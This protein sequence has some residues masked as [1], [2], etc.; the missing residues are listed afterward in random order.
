MRRRRKER[1]VRNSM[2][3]TDDEWARI[4]AAAAEAGEG[5]GRHI[6]RRALTDDPSPNALP[7]ASQA[8]AP[9]EQ[10]AMHDAILRLSGSASETA[11]PGQSWLTV[12]P[13][14]IRFLFEDRIIAMAREG[15]SEDLHAQFRS[16]FGAEKGQAMAAAF[17][18]RLNVSDSG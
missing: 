15:R 5:I 2:S 16:V 9:E 4:Q 11:V 12:L 7:R 13:G 18:R 8:L 17:L 1:V 14:C 3:C 10:R 6:V